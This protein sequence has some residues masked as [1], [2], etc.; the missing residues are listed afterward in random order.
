M[1]IID[2]VVCASSCTRRTE[3]QQESQSRF[4]RGARRETEL[5]RFRP[6]EEAHCARHEHDFAS[7]SVRTARFTVFFSYC[8]PGR[9]L[10]RQVK[11]KTFTPALP[12]L[13]L[14]LVHR[15]ITP[16][17]ACIIASPDYWVIEQSWLLK[18]SN[19]S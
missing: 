18:S 19:G 4:I 3:S 2:G 17:I 14:N 12:H 9:S 7:G 16:V 11:L 8:P 15:L 10:R 13:L 1:L 5:I 6:I